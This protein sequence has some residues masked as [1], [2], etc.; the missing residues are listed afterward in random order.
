MLAASA[1]L[2]NIKLVILDGGHNSPAEQVVSVTE[3]H[4]AHVDDAENMEAL[5]Q[6][7]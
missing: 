6:K 2:L 1:S 3:S 5:T 4:L 7:G